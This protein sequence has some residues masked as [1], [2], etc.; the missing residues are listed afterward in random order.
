MYKIA[1]K[2]NRIGSRFS[3]SRNCTII[4]LMKGV[5]TQILRWTQHNDVRDSILRRQVPHRTSSLGRLRKFCI[6]KIT[7]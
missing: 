6:L 7:L 1:F 2:L 3:S 5:S 4:V